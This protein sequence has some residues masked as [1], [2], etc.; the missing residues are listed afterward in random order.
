MFMY[1]IDRVWFKFLFFGNWDIDHK[2][3]PK[4]LIKKIEKLLST[5]EKKS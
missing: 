2:A 1:F 3:L 4:K 5:H